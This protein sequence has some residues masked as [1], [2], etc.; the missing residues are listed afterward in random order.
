MVSFMGVAAVCLGLLEGSP[1][2]GEVCDGDTDLSARWMHEGVAAAIAPANGSI[3]LLSRTPEWGAFRAAMMARD[4][5]SLDGADVVIGSADFEAARDMRSVCE[6][7]RVGF[8]WASSFADAMGGVDEAHVAMELDGEAQAIAQALAATADEGP[9]MLVRDD[10]FLG[11][12]LGDRLTLALEAL[13]RVVE[14]APAGEPGEPDNAFWD[15]EHTQAKTVVVVGSAGSVVEVAKFLATS[16]YVA[17][18]AVVVSMLA[19]PRAVIDGL[20]DVV[21]PVLYAT[22]ELVDE[23]GSPVRGFR[24]SV[25]TSEAPYGASEQA[26]AGYL[27]GV[28]VRDAMSAA[29]A[30]GDRTRQRDIG[31]AFAAVRSKVQFGAWTLKTAAELRDE[32]PPIADADERGL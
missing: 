6:A 20:E 24:E 7:Y 23:E 13:G 2:V 30:R 5:I 17:E 12:T 22:R 18:G 19:E 32:D 29:A 25:G 21:T 28:A 26:F 14:T 9:I 4:L 10:R 16:K 27:A 15:L 8:V 11:R 1:I 3:E 31:E